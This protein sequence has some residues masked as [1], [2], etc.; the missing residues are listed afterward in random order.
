MLRKQI[1]STF[2][3]TATTQRSLIEFF[4]TIMGAIIV[5]LLFPN[6]EGVLVVL[7]TAVW[8]S[9]RLLRNFR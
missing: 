2:F 3:M 6:P 9:Y 8:A 4:S 1:Y 5:L 7:L